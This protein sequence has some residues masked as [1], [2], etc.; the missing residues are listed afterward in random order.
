MVEENDLIFNRPWK[1]KEVRDDMMLLENQ[2][3]FFILEEF[4]ALAKIRVSLGHTNVKLVCLTSEQISL[5]KLTHEFFWFKAYLACE[6]GEIL[7]K[8]RHY[9]CGIKHFVDFFRKCHVPREHPPS[10]EIRTVNLPSTTELHEVGVKVRMGSS[11]NLFDIQ[12]RNRVLV[13]P[14]LQIRSPTESFFLNMLAYEQSHLRD[15]FFILDRLINTTSDVE[16]L[17]QSGVIESKLADSQEVVDS[18]S[19]L[20]RG[21]FWRRKRFYF[22][23]LCDGLNAHYANPWNNWITTIIHNH[24]SSPY[25]VFVVTTATVLFVL[26]LIQTVCSCGVQFK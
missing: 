26:T 4:F 20:V 10:G 18:I 14:Q 21:S 24:F 8:M 12:F 17:T 2:L 7:K 5:I 1:V 13:I 11:K 3:P 22:N 25:T 6:K 16:L 9:S 15:Y 23:E 19:H